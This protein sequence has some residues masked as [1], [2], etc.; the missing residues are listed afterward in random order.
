MAVV[1]A[2]IRF[3]RRVWSVSSGNSLLHS[4]RVSRSLFFWEEHSCLLSSG[5]LYRLLASA[6]QSVH[7][8][9]NLPPSSLTNSSW[10]I[11]MLRLP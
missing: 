10:H 7:L 2:A 3:P 6:P 5:S 11:L 9:M 8:W 1:S 4:L